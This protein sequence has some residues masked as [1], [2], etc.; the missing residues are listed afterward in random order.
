MTKRFRRGPG[1]WRSTPKGVWHGFRN[2]S[3]TEETEL[4]WAWCGGASRD[5][6]GYEVR[7]D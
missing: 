2:T 6:V 4:I 3:D 7:K 1:T 5:E